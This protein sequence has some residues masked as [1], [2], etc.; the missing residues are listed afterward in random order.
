[1]FKFTIYRDFL[2]SRAVRFKTAILIMIRYPRG[3]GF[4]AVKIEAEPLRTHS[5]AER[6]NEGK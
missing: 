6:E 2:Q 5:Q 1:M 3:C 4:P